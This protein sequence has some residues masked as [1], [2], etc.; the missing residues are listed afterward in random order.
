MDK[1]QFDEALIYAISNEVEAEEFYR[2]VSDK[3]ADPFLKDLFL[4]LSKE[5]KTHQRI[6]EGFRGKA[7]EAF[8]FKEVPDYNVS[9]N[10]ARPKLTTDLKPAE[11][12]ALAMKNEEEAM[13]QYL[14]LAESTTDA[15]M[16][17]VFSELAAMEREHKFAMEKAFVDIG[18][19]EVW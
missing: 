6:L 11:A 4:R 7:P 2:D 19:P 14:R 17:K 5:E 18:Y 3:M 13:N 15:E 10:V 9:A 12:F 16:K 1:N 8:H